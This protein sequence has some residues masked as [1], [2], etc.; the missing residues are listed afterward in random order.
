[1]SWHCPIKQKLFQ[2]DKNMRFLGQK[3]VKESSAP[4]LK[5]ILGFLYFYKAE[6]DSA[7]N[8]MFYAKNLGSE[9]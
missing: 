1:M 3:I 8:V 9:Y 7:R 4:I 5:Q 6:G 2:S